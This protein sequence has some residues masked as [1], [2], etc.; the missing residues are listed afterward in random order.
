MKLAEHPT[1]KRMRS[2]QLPL[3]A[4]NHARLDAEWL[5][6]LVL[7]AGADD[8]GFVE[9]DRPERRAMSACAHM[10]GTVMLSRTL[11][12]ESSARL[13]RDVARAVEE[14]FLERRGV[15]QPPTTGEES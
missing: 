4:E 2:R 1:V 10:A 7:E 8:V 5:R 9:I 12:P 15:T 3:A 14:T 6:R 13:R 11:A